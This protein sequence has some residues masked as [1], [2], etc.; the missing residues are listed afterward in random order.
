MSSPPTLTILLGY[1]SNA[2][3]NDKF[4]LNNATQGTLNNSTY[5]LSG[6]TWVDV[7]AYVSGSFSTSRGRSR[8]TEQYQ[9]GTM[10]F[11]L[12]N[13]DRR[14][15]PSNTATPYG[16]P[17]KPRMQVQALVNGYPIFTGFVDD[18]TVNYE[19]PNICTVTVNCLD[20]FSVLSNMRLINYSASSASSGSVIESAIL[21]GGYTGARQLSSSGVTIQA[22]TATDSDVLSYCQTI[23]RSELGY[24]YVNP[25]GIITFK[26]RYEVVNSATNASAVFTDDPTDTNKKY[27]GITQSSNTLLFWNEVTGERNG[28]GVK[29]TVRNGYSADAYQVRSQ[30]LGTLENIDNQA[31]LNLVNLYLSKYHSPEIRMES[32]TVNM[33]DMS[34]KSDPLDAFFDFL[35]LLLLDLTDVIEVKRTPPGT[36]TPSV[37]DFVSRV[38]GIAYSWDVSSDNYSMKLTLGSVDTREWFILDDA[39]RGI[40]DT[41]YL[42]Y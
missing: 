8:E 41:N 16:Q 24:F 42:A 30:S 32:I 11:T 35:G 12:R 21:Y 29:Q 5:V 2:T 1:T 7:S 25:F 18:I 36:G 20:A 37:L 38:E 26:S 3:A 27:T 6:F 23:A 17:I 10:Q 14:F 33:L 19:K 13:E 40:L 9:C 28:S 15:D 31:V 4:I 34:R 22:T 39:T